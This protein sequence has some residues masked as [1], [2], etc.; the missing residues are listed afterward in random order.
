METFAIREIQDSPFT[1]SYGT[2]EIKSVI[3]GYFKT[4]SRVSSSSSSPTTEG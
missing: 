4:D 2:V 3:F 1:A